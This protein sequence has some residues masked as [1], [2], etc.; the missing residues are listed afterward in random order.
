[1]NF[2]KNLLF[3]S[4]GKNEGQ[5][6]KEKEN[7]TEKIPNWGDESKLQDIIKDLFTKQKI[8]NEKIEE[9]IKKLH[10]ND[11]YTLKQWKL[12]TEEDKNGYK[13][14]FRNLLDEV[15]KGISFF[16]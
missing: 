16:N 15:V 2:N 11:I 5:E 3:N 9:L 12:L 13:R 10:Y 1:M 4:K 7:K 8:S 14:G 6:Q